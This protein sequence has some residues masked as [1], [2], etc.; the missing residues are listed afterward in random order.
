MLNIEDVIQYATKK[1]KG[2]K[3]LS[4]QPYILHPLNLMLKMGNDSERI[5]ALL[6]DVI[7]DTDTTLL[8]LEIDLG[9][10]D[11]ML[12]AIDLLT[13]DEK[14]DY[15]DMIKRIKKHPIARKV[16]IAD[17]EHNMDFHRTLGR[18]CMN[19]KD[20]NRIAKYYQA[21]VYLIGE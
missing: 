17:L 14:E 21:R 12:V 5:V 19:E 16:K 7:E 1:H 15:M 10:T 3:D 2:Q 18:E 9:L 8:D 13:K 20:K 4:G 11:E 6:H